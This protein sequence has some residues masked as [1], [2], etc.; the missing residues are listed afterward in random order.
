MNSKDVA[1]RG[2]DWPVFIG[3]VVTLVVAGIVTNSLTGIDGRY[4]IAALGGV[5]FMVVGGSGRPER[6]LGAFRRE[7]FFSRFGTE[8]AARLAIFLTGLIILLPTLLLLSK[9]G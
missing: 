9:V 7:F 2:R 4:A 5:I 8:A 3:M 6:L 1:S